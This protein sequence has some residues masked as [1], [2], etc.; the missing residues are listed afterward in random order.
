[1]TPTLHV[2]D[3]AFRAAIAESSPLAKVRRALYDLRPIR[4]PKLIEAAEAL[5][6]GQAG[7]AKRIAAKFLAK[8]PRNP[9]ALNIMAELAKR[10]RNANEEELYLTQCVRWAPD[11]QAYRYNYVLVLMERNKLKGALAET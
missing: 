9:D 10:A 7:E 6:K 8:H 11:H 5:E 1:M 4:D 3:I 2:P